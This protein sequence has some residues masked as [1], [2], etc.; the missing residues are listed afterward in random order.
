LWHTV[1]TGYNQAMR[2]RLRSLL[3]CV[4]LLSVICAAAGWSWRRNSA[5]QE[6]V[7]SLIAHQARCHYSDG[8]RLGPL[9]EWVDARLGRAFRSDVI[10]VY[11]DDSN[12][13]DP[14]VVSALRRLPGLRRVKV[15]CWAGRDEAWAKLKSELQDTDVDVEHERIV[16]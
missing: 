1:P 9:E 13:N 2:Y 7:E 10:T 11:V 12:A 3:I 4:S 14:E 16:W 6:A 8:V 5:E 15:A